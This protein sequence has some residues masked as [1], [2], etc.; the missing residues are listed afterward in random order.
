MIYFL[1]FV[2]FSMSFLALAYGMKNSPR[3]NLIRL[4]EEKRKLAD[5]AKRNMRH[6][7]HVRHSKDF[8]EIIKMISRLDRENLHTRYY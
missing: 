5:T 7:E 3:N 6:E 1:S 4:L 8:E 2:I